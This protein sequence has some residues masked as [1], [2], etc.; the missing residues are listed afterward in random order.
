MSLPQFTIV[1]LGAA[2]DRANCASGDGSLDSFIK[3]QAVQAMRDRTCAVFV[4]TPVDD[5]TQVVGYYTLSPATI[6]TEGVPEDRRAKLPRYPELPA[7]LL[8]RLAVHGAYGGK[9]LGSLLIANALRRTETQR[10]LP[11]M[12]L[13]VDAYEQARGFY[14][15]LGF[16]PVVN[17]QT[18]LFFALSRLSRGAALAPEV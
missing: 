2:H 15:K 18:R 4:A 8:G 12:F 13:V 10:E 14:Q 16:V 5:L 1:R 17:S 3:E 6:P 9:G 11:V 7:A